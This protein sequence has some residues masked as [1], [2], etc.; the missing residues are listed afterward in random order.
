MSRLAVAAADAATL[1]DLAAIA[2]EAQRDPERHIAYFGDAREE[3]EAEIAEVDSWVDGTHVVRRDGRLV[4]WLLA[5]TEADLRRVWWWGPVVAAG[6]SWDTAA[7]ALYSAARARLDNSFDQE[8]LAADARSQAFGAFAERQ[9]FQ[10]DAASTLLRVEIG[11]TTPDP[12]VTTLDSAGFEQVIAL[13]DS[14]FPGAHATGRHL[15]DAADGYRLVLREN[16]RVAGY[17]AIE[18]QPGGEGYIDFLGVDPTHRGR[19][20]GG[21]LVATA[22]DVLRARDVTVANLTVRQTNAAARSVYRRLGFAE[23]RDIRPFRKGFTLSS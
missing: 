3:I 4:G 21:A 7:E 9:G 19:G 13:H 18:I 15:V 17:I 6:E 1:T 11:E 22:L 2:E 12:R 23:L 20:A 16:G 5:E 10:A 14:L 8:E